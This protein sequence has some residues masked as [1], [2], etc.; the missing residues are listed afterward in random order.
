MASYRY[1]SIVFVKVVSRGF[2]SGLE[3]HNGWNKLS[4][5]IGA[6]SDPEPV[7]RA[8]IG[9]AYTRIKSVYGG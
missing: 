9:A 1:R 6:R 4:K 7:V 8:F 2:Y 3:A 5:R